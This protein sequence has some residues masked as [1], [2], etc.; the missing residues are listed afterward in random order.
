VCISGSMAPVRAHVRSATKK[1]RSIGLEEALSQALRVV[2]K[3]GRPTFAKRKSAG[4]PA[5]PASQNTR[6]W[7]SHC[8]VLGV[9]QRQREDDGDDHDSCDHAQSKKYKRT[10]CMV[11]GK[12][13]TGKIKQN[14]FFFHV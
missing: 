4:D 7:S 6:M 10:P 13:W 3:T 12:N 9:A 8:C 11:C 1:V 14:I 5:V 2:E